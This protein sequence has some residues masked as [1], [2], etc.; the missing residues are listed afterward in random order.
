MLNG[1]QGHE[2]VTYKFTLFPLGREMEFQESLEQVVKDLGAFYFGV[3]DLS[4]TKRGV[5]TPH[6]QKLIYEYPFAIVKRINHYKTL[7][8]LLKSNTL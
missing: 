3:A 8:K 4:L 1:G 5:M 7:L 6:E 2:P